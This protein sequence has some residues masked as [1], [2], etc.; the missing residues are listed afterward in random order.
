[1]DFIWYLPTIS[2][3]SGHKHQNCSI[4]EDSKKLTDGVVKTS[5][6]LHMSQG[7]H[8]AKHTQTHYSWQ[9]INSFTA[10]SAHHSTQ[11]A[12]VDRFSMSP[13]CKHLR[14]RSLT[15]LFI[16]LSWNDV[17]PKTAS[18]NSTDRADSAVQ[19]LPHTIQRSHQS[20]RH[21]SHF[22]SFLTD[23]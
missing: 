18:W 9:K 15:R 22:T 7:E 2:I 19:L 10:K 5:V 4:Y 13:A 16:T 11:Q 17:L 8:K 23:C 3:H 14:A 1:M 20:R 12:S 21:W 6:H